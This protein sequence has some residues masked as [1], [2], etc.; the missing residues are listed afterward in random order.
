MQFIS[1]FCGSSKGHHPIYATVAANLGKLLAEENITLVYGGGNVGLMGILA[2]A[3]LEKEGKVIGVIPEFLDKWEVGHHGITELIILDNM[4]QRKEKM[5]EMSDG[6]IIMPGGFGTMDEFF[7][8]LTWK[9]LHLHTSPIGILNINGYY[10]ILLQQVDKMVKEGFV[11]AEN[12]EL[13]VVDADPTVLL[14]KMK[15]HK[16]ASV[17]GKWVG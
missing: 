16:T 8:I 10:D 2:D 5:Y 6:Y 1:V 14:E 7:E 13:M 17:T 15:A 9:Q 11:R 4:H 12:L 3:M